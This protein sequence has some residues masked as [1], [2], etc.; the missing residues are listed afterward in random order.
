[1]NAY[2][3]LF[4]VADVDARGAVMNGEL[5]G[6]LD[7]TEVMWGPWQVA[8]PFMPTQTQGPRPHLEPPY[9]RVKSLKSARE[10]V[11]RDRIELSTLRFSVVCSTN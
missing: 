4:Y 2:D 10:V 8:T 5:H 9:R 11:A 3:H 7:T 1:M 6:A